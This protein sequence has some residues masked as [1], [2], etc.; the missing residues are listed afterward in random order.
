MIENELKTILLAASE[1]KDSRGKN[2]ERACKSIAQKYN[3]INARANNN[4]AAA[5]GSLANYQDLTV[6]CVDMMQ[7]HGYTPLELTTI[8]K[9][10]FVRWYVDNALK[11]PK[12]KPA[13]I[14]R[15]ILEE[16]ATGFYLFNLE[17]DREPSNYMELRDW[18]INWESIIEK[19][20]V[21]S[22]KKLT[23]ARN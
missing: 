14:T 16:F 4:V 22:I 9:D 17:Y 6:K 11:E 18:V 15:A 12:Y 3:S 7:L 23:N 20:L 10:D 13:Y 8:F 21:E 5:T 2:I 1:M 19:N